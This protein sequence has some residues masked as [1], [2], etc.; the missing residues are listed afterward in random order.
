M[1]F[2]EPEALH[3]DGLIDHIWS[4]T[5]FEPCNKAGQI[6]VL[7]LSLASTDVPEVYLPK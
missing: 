2:V 3:L 5:Q 6:F 7:Y 1:C 4:F